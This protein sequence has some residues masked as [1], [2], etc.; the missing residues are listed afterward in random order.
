M[1]SLLICCTLCFAANMMP[2]VPGLRGELHVVGVCGVETAAMVDI[3]E[4][5]VSEDMADRQYGHAQSGFTAFQRSIVSSRLCRPDTGINSLMHMHNQHKTIRIIFS[6]LESPRFSAHGFQMQPYGPQK[7][8]TMILA[9][10]MEGIIA[11]QIL[12]EGG[13]TKSVFYCFLAYI[14]LPTLQGQKRCILMDNLPSVHRSWQ[15][16]RLLRHHGHHVVYR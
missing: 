1:Q 16:D 4:F 14:L 8:Q 13:S 9:H 6:I 10:G 12:P 11:Y 15:T 2:G 7:K 5:P 3:D